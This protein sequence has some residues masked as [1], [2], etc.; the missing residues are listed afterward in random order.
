[1]VEKEKKRVITDKKDENPNKTKKIRFMAQVE[2]ITK[3]NLSRNKSSNLQILIAE[4]K[5]F[6]EDEPKQQVEQQAKLLNSSNSNINKDND[7]IFIEK[8]KYDIQNNSVETSLIHS[9]F[10][11][12]EHS[13][14]D[15]NRSAK[16]CKGCGS[17]ILFKLGKSTKNLWT[18]YRSCLKSD[19][20]QNQNL[21]EPYLKKNHYYQKKKQIPSIIVYIKL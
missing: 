10:N 13:K 2:E 17:E 20:Q 11:K 18:H 12:V 21:I 6:Q 5:E 14:K 19:Y 3:N 7:K 16:E 15:Y 9:K 1:M 4:E 8:I